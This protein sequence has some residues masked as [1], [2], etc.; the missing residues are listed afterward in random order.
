[1]RVA[2]TNNQGGDQWN[3]V[4]TLDY[5]CRSYGVLT[6]IAPGERIYSARYIDKRLYL[7]TFRQVDPFFVISFASFR[8]PIILGELKITG[9]SS[10]LHPYDETTILG[11]GRD[12]TTSGV[13]GALKIA[14][15]DVADPRNPRLLSSA[16][17][18]EAYAA[19]SAEWEHKAFLFSRER[20][21]L[22]VPGSLNNGQVKFN[23]AF[24]FSVARTSISISGMID[25]LVNANDN[26]SIRT[27]ERSLYIEN[28]LYTKSKCL[29]RINRIDSQFTAV[30]N[31][32]IPCGQSTT[33]VINPVGP[34][35]RPA[36]LPSF[37]PSILPAIQ[38][39]RN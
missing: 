34:F 1:M 27:V 6:R 16:T 7:V 18:T 21:I 37:L 15:F 26:F 11:F 20:N 32:N 13:V 17:V 19:S 2:T 5:Y 14:L 35:I 25:H 8:A 23:G 38:P 10:Y 4:Y 24:V 29:L 28:I 31:I 33:G 12:A 22:V 9:Y 30:S 3:N 36:V 39:L